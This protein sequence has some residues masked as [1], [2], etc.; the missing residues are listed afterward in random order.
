MSVQIPIRSIVLAAPLVVWGVCFGVPAQ[1][2]PANDC[3]AAPKSPAPAGQHWYYHTDRKK[4]RKCWFLR[5]L[6][7]PA[8]SAATPD[9]STAAPTTPASKAEQPAAESANAS[10]PTSAAHRA[11]SSEPHPA[12][13]PAPANNATTSESVQQDGQ[14]KTAAPSFPRAP[15]QAGEWTDPPAAAATPTVPIVWPDLRPVQIIKIRK[16]NTD[17]SNAASDAVKP[18][19]AVRAS[20]EPKK[21]ASSAAPAKPAIMTEAATSPVITPVE[22]GL[23]VV[24]ALAVAG[25]LYHLVIKIAASRRRRNAL[26]FTPPVWADDPHRR[27]W[28]SEPRPQA[29]RQAREQPAAVREQFVDGSHVSLVPAASDDSARQSP[30]VTDAHRMF[31]PRKAAKA[32]CSGPVSEHEHNLA[33][34]IRDL[35]QLL[36][37]RKGA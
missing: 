26:N 29:P 9:K 3:L 37:A 7:S 11:S 28:R 1:A 10:K 32:P 33:Q 24:F 17:T 35:D 6:N 30:R 2:A 4:G 12:P 27:P 20:S 19:D 13:N 16:P 34:L 14:E 31:A 23:V 22:M 18:T 8:Q 25:L 5:E 15:A 21:T 36:Q